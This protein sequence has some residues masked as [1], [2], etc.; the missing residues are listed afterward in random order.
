MKL[1]DAIIELR[2]GKRIRLTS[3]EYIIFSLTDDLGYV[4]N[5]HELISEKWEVVEEPGKTFPE[6]F[7]AFKEGARIK[8]KNWDG[9]INYFE[10]RNLKSEDLL[11]TDWEIIDDCQCGC[12][13]ALENCG[14][15][16]KRWRS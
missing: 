10:F 7:E 12:H 4:L 15:C 8:R 11:A 13:P 6:V 2:K 1:E 3:S 9:F 14:D 16:C 5:A